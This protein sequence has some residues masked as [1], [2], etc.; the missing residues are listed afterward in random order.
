MSTEVDVCVVGA[1]LAGLSAADRMARGGAS[2]VVLEA[3]ERIGGRLLSTRIGEGTFD[4]G[5]Q[6]IGK[7]QRRAWALAEELSVETFPTHDAGEKI[8]WLGGRARRY[9]GTIPKLDPLSLLELQLTL[10]RIDRMRRTVAMKRPCDT[11]LAEGLD[12]QTVADW[13]QHHVRSPAVRAVMDAAVRVVF[14]VEPRELS[15]LTF[16]FYVQGCGGLMPLVEIEGGAQETRFVDGAQRLAFGLRERLARSAG[17]DVVRVS[18]PVRRVEVR[19]EAITVTHDGGE[20]RARRV[21]M[22]IPPSL[23]RRIAF[24]PALPAARRTVI[25]RSPIGATT[26]HVL[27]Y[28]RAFWR[29]DGLSGEV[30]CDDGPFSVVFDNTSFDGAQPA[31]LAFAVGQQA[32]ELAQMSENGRKARVQTRLGEILGPLARNPTAHVEK[33]WAS[34]PWTRGCPVGLATNGVLSEIGDAL[35][36][37]TGLIHWA[38]TETATEHHGFMEGALQSGERAAEEALA[39]LSR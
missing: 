5:A 22:A 1:G 18:C 4:L 19:G 35:H 20:V 13:E 12:A 11:P 31:L 26:K 33:D 24:S 7:T 16:L 34:E 3:R 10:T 17:E 39:A 2:V 29:E 27:L 9:A 36:A 21:V 37:P 23:A 38:G 14:G 25:D 6:W 15:L 8:L 32:R 28:E 30:V